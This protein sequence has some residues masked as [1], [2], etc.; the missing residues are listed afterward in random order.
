M[1]GSW[2]QEPGR[3]GLELE[4]CYLS[5]VGLGLVYKPFKP[6]TLHLWNADHS[7]PYII[8]SL[9]GPH[10]ALVFINYPASVFFFLQDWEQRRKSQGV[11]KEKSERLHSLYFLSTHLWITHQPHWLCKPLTW[12]CS[13]KSHKGPSWNPTNIFFSTSF[14]IIPELFSSYKNPYH[15]P[16]QSGPCH[17]PPVLL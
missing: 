3:A 9:S 8:R 4:A 10:N 14:D 17:F 12:D 1:V 5:T 13:S 6:C 11:E 7:R 2:A 15:C 16:W